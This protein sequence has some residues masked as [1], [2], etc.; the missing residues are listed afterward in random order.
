MNTLKLRCLDC[1]KDSDVISRDDEI[2]KVNAHFLAESLKDNKVKLSPF[3]LAI[4]KFMRMHSGHRIAI[5]NQFNEVL[6][7]GEFK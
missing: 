7:K 2:M 4:G 1:N 5:V 6:C 3:F